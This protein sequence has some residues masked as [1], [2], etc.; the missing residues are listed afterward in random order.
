MLIV[1]SNM[2]EKRKILIAFL[3][4]STFVILYIIHDSFMCVTNFSCCRLICSGYQ[5]Y[6]INNIITK[7]FAFNFVNC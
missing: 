3:V 1:K 7:G 5:I 4:S 6:T 2:R